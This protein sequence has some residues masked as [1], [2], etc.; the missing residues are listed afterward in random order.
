MNLNFSWWSL[1]KKWTSIIIMDKNL[2]YKSG[3]LTLEE[4]KRFKKCLKLF[5]MSRNK[6]IKYW[7]KMDG[8]E[9]FM[10]LRKVLLN[11]SFALNIWVILL[12]TSKLGLT[13]GKC[14]LM[15]ND[16][17]DKLWWG[18]FLEILLTKSFRIKSLHF[19]LL[20]QIKFKAMIKK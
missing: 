2:C 13:F 10:F 16:Q 14:F 3:W 5:L 7:R 19:L 9:F 18:K 1:M 15:W 17:R 8:K 6:L 20:N 11:K 12:L 4:L